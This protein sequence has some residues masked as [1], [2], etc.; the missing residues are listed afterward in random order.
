MKAAI[1]SNKVTGNFEENRRT[2]LALAESALDMG[3]ELIVFPEAA[4]TGLADTGEV[5]HDLRIAET[6]SGPLCE[7]WG[8]FAKSS[9]VWFAAGLL[10]REGARIYDSYVFFD[11]EGNLALHYRRIDPHWHRPEDDPQIYCVG[12]GVKT[13]MTPFGKLGVLVCGDVW[14]DGIVARM[15][16]LEPEYL[17]YPF[18]R[19]RDPGKEWPAELEE[20]CKRFSMIGARTLAVNLYEGEGTD[21]S[22]GGAWFV[23]EKGWVLSSLPMEGEGILFV[24]TAA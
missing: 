1:V 19:A 22:F 23:D 13:V 8:A 10:E 21:D 24:D 2:I 11:P 16:A 12:E 7:E 9:K 3:A 20:Y 14:D 6:V 4:A 18:L 15:K 17:L 5:K